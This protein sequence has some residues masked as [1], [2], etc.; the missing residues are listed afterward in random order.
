MEG[1]ERE[2]GEGEEEKKAGGEGA[3]WTEVWREEIK[4]GWK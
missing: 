4:R 3:A 1:E 2:R